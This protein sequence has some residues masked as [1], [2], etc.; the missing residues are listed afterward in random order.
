MTDHITSDEQGRNVVPAPV[1]GVADEIQAKKDRIA[2]ICKDHFHLVDPDFGDMTAKKMSVLLDI[3]GTVAPGYLTQIAAFPTQK[4]RSVITMSKR[5]SDVKDI[6][7]HLGVTPG[8]VRTTLGMAVR[9]GVINGYI[10]SGRNGLA[11]K[12]GTARRKFKKSVERVSAASGVAAQHDAKPVEKGAPPVLQAAISNE[13]TFM[14][15]V[16]GPSGT[17]D[18]TI[19]V[20]PIEVGIILGSLQE[21]RKK[22]SE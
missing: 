15:I 3:E 7:I 2:M 13:S 20:R 10:K 8:Y 1:G 22:V 12:N 14:K 9:V 17:I 6:A 11:G 4:Q 19:R 18:F 5:G 21:F 16:D